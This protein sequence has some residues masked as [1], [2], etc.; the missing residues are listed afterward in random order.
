MKTSLATS[1]AAHHH[2]VPPA[3]S[4]L[5]ANTARSVRREEPQTARVLPEQEVCKVHE[6]NCRPTT[7]QRA[8]QVVLSRRAALGLAGASL[9]LLGPSPPAEAASSASDSPLPDGNAVLISS[10]D[11][12]TLAPSEKQVYSLNKRIQAQNR[13]PEDFPG[14]VR[15]GFDVKVVGDGYSVTPSGLFYKDFNSGQGPLPIDGQEVVFQYTGYNE[16]G[17]VIDTSYR[18]N[19]PA[20][21]RLGIAGLIPGFEEGIRGMKAGQQ[22]RIVIPPALGPPV[23]PSTFFSAKQCEVFDIELIAIKTCER[24]QLAMFSDVVCT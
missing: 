5:R 11:L 6:D 17:A 18:K 24:R 20:Q 16:S 4:Q 9:A 23:G 14:F 13:T 22:R 1:H 10:A 12:P 8:P 19:R 3:T 15:T 7:L 21:T 2:I